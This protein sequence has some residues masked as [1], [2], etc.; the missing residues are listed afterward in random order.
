MVISVSSLKGGVG[1][2][3][4]TQNLAVCFAHMEYSVCI[5]DADTNQ[6][7]L[8]W[9]ENRQE[10]LPS[11]TVGSYEDGKTLAK[12]ISKLEKKFD[13]VLIDG[14]PS[15]SELT[16]RV[17]FLSDFLIIPILS[18]AMDIRATQKFLT[19]YEKAVEEKGIPIPAYILLNQ[20]DE[21]LSLSKEVKEVVSSLPNV[22]ILKT[23]LGYRVAYKEAN[24]K[25]I[26]VYEYSNKKA[27]S[28]L[29]KLTKEVLKKISKSK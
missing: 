5:A 9:S 26:G 1:K 29:I 21:R 23:T 7:C 24:I 10:A 28:E 18:G 11:I 4:I 8:H 2:S 6:S 19:R 13:I 25:G 20:F 3:T 12:K 17:I 15:L 14:T 27:K 16:S 22:K